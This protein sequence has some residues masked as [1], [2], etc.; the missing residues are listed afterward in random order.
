MMNDEQRRKIEEAKGFGSSHEWC[1]RVPA[2]FGSRNGTKEYIRCLSGRPPRPGSYCQWM[3]PTFAVGAVGRGSLCLGAS[4]WSG[5][6]ST[7]GYHEWSEVWT[8]VI[9]H[10]RINGNGLNIVDHIIRSRL[11]EADN[12]SSLFHPLNC[13]N[14]FRKRFIEREFTNDFVYVAQLKTEPP[15]R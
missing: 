12:W 6:A 13:L 1:L 9:A 5:M 3:P 4:E 14:L 10:A 7:S 8:D 15:D 2:S 11:L